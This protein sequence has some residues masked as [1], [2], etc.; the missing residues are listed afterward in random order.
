MDCF[1]QTNKQKKSVLFYK[2][3]EKP[4]QEKEMRVNKTKVLYISR[5]NAALSVSPPDLIETMQ[6]RGT[7]NHT[8]PTQ[9]GDENSTQKS[10]KYM[11]EKIEIKMKTKIRLHKIFL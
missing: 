9:A 4:Q 6:S 10:A 2:T 1:H 5:P 3:K 8:D 7:A 11:D